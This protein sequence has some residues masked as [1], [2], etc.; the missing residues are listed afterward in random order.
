[1]LAL[2]TLLITA[3]ISFFFLF[4]AQNTNIYSLPTSLDF[5]ALTYSFL[6]LVCF[7]L[8]FSIPNPCLLAFALNSTP[9]LFAFAFVFCNALAV[10]SHGNVTLWGTCVWWVVSGL[11]LTAFFCKGGDGM[12][13]H[14][15]WLLGCAWWLSLLCIS[16]SSF[17]L[18]RFK[19]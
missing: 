4:W 15:R 2:F 7:L 1:M 18:Y 17:I 3:R 19:K 5:T 16:L 9:S 8:F 12:Y 11:W 14:A 6:L 13:H 10:G